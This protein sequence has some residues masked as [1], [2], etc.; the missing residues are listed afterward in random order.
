MEESTQTHAG[1]AVAAEVVPSSSSS[2]VA[3]AV[4]PKI[5][6]EEGGGGR[7]R[8]KE[9]LGA[10]TTTTTHT[11][12]AELKFN[13]PA[14]YQPKKGGKQQTWNSNNKRPDTS[15]AAGERRDGAPRRKKVGRKITMIVLARYVH[16]SL[17]P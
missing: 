12:E 9:N 11:E 15:R 10:T 5:E 1:S 14:G 8:V 13:Q 3:V 6:K 4:S 17:T 16:V 7:E 2:E